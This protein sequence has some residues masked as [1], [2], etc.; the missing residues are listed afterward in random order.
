M[1]VFLNIKDWTKDDWDRE[2]EKFKAQ[3]CELF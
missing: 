3:G 1:F 2:V